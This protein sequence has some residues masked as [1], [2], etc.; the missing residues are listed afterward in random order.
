[1]ED[2]LLI[3]KLDMVYRDL[4]VEDAQ[5]RY[6]EITVPAPASEPAPAPAPV[7][8]K[9]KPKRKQIKALVPASK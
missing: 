2:S 4:P 7:P 9:P 3:L 5:K 6:S 1:M 8:P